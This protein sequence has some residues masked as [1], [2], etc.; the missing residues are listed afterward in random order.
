M[1]MSRARPALLGLLFALALFQA[2]GG[3]VGVLLGATAGPV[4]GVAASR[5]LARQ[6][7][8]RVVAEERRVAADLPFTADLLAAALRA[9]AA[10]DVAARCVAA[11][12]GGPVGQ[13]LGRVETALRL[14]APAD[15]AWAYLG[16]VDGGA[17][18]VQAAVRSQHSGAAFA[19]AL[20]RLADDLRA[21]RLI[22]ADAA[23]RRAGVL[24][25][26]PLGLCFLPAFVLAGLVPVVVAVLGDVLSP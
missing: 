23:A 14:G 7:S 15:Q 11:A 8:R 21:D 25:V 17:R 20:H 1:T 18:I 22:A 26:L 19:A 16:R 4:L 24:I 6:P 13:R 12:V 5:W 10:P 2:V 3:W 9:G